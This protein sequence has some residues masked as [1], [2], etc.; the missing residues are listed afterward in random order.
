MHPLALSSAKK[1]R[2]R[3]SFFFLFMSLS[4]TVP[5][6]QQVY[7][8]GQEYTNAPMEPARCERLS[9]QT[10]TM[11][12]GTRVQ[13]AGAAPSLATASPSPVRR[14]AGD[15]RQR[16]DMARTVVLAELDKA[17]QRHA[18]LVQDYRKAQGKSE[19][20]PLKAAVERA[21]RDI[22]SLQRELDRRPSVSAQP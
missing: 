3:P 10:V 5:A 17:R 9:P 2:L 19:D 20:A 15:Q 8:C 7:R 21:Q 6:Q 1:G 4:A 11:V 22:D 13:S 16:D 12:P 14:E 18:A